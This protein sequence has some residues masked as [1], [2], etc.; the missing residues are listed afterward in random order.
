MILQSISLLNFKNHIDSRVDFIE[1][2]NCFVGDNGAGKTNMLDA[3]HYLSLTKS[4][5]TKQDALNIYN[6]EPF[7]AIEGR[8]LKDETTD[9]IHIGV[10]SGLKKTIKRNKKT[11]DRLSDHIGLFPI[12]M[13]SPTDVELLNSGSDYRRKF[14]DSIIAQ[15]DKNYLL[16]LIKY[17]K[18]IG[19]RNALL[20][21]M[22]KSNSFDQSTL[23]VYD[24]QIEP[25]VKSIHQKRLDFLKEFIPIFKKYYHL[26][27]N[28]D[29]NVNIEYQSQLTDSDYLDLI[30]NNTDK[31]RF[32]NSSYYGVHKDD[33]IFNLSGYLIKKRGSQGQ[34]KTFLLSLKLAQ[35]DFMK[36]TL[37][38]EPML[39]LDDIFD[40]LDDNRV[41]HLMKLVGDKH[42]GQIFVTDTHPMRSSQIF[43]KIGVNYK[44]FNVKKGAIEKA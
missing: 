21:Q 40:K 18:L 28:S 30:N 39:L 37:K 26:I 4:Y 15:F 23:S 19:Q 22:S 3:I 14:M 20:K 29:E 27:S 36:S 8:F 41:E 6:N 24:Y 11:Y 43:E 34:Q 25:L 17:N 12:V 7:M 9:V 31:E 32:S 38:F 42:F 2:I 35:Y 13:I 44:L 5:F 16:K 33:L 1:G 10:K